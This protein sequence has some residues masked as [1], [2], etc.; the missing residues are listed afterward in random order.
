MLANVS[1]KTTITKASQNLLMLKKFTELTVMT[2]EIPERCRKINS[3]LIS[4]KS[5]SVFENNQF[6]NSFNKNV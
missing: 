3:A 2:K 5:S 4:S 6:D 1:S